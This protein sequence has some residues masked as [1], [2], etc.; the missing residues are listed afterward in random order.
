MV[1][2]T[3]RA[4]TAETDDRDPTSFWTLPMR[5]PLDSSMARARS[6]VPRSS[7]NWA[8]ALSS[9]TTGRLDRASLKK[10]RRAESSPSP[11]RG[12]PP[13]VRLACTVFLQT[14]SVLGSDVV[15]PG[16]AT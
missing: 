3:S 14:E 5:T 8:N 16:G 13:F 7:F 4:F 9:F 1:R 11:R 15:P 6:L 2:L 12:H 10:S